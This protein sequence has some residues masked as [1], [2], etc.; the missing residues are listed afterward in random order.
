MALCKIPSRTRAQLRSSMWE[1][2]N[3]FAREC[4]SM[5]GNVCFQ[6]CVRPGLFPRTC[7][8]MFVSKNVFRHVC[9]REHVPK[10]LVPR[11]CSYMSVSKA[12]FRHVC[13]Q[14]CVQTCL[15]PRLCSDMSVS[16]N[17][18]RHVCWFLQTF[19]SCR[20]SRPSHVEEKRKGR[21]CWS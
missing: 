12:V 4:S 7:S 9:F 10:C 16:T 1:K 5:F 15:F 17:V 3:R 8:D 19:G 6:G 14:A 11:L 2:K 18:F 21:C 13:L 20:V